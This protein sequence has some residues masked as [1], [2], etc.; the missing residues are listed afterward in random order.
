MAGETIGVEYARLN[1]FSRKIPTGLTQPINASCLCPDSSL[2]RVVGAKEKPEIQPSVQLTTLK[3][4]ALLSG[5]E[6]LYYSYPQG[7]KKPAPDL[8]TVVLDSKL[9]QLPVYNSLPEELFHASSNEVRRMIQKMIAASQKRFQQDVYSSFFENENQESQINMH[10]AITLLVQNLQHAL[11]MPDSES[12]LRIYQP[13]ER[14][15]AE[16]I[17]SIV[18][19]HILPTSLPG[20]SEKGRFN[21]DEVNTMVGTTFGRGDKVVTLAEFEE[22]S[23]VSDGERYGWIDRQRVAG[24]KE[25]ATYKDVQPVYYTG[26]QPYFYQTAIGESSSILPGDT[27]YQKGPEYFVIRKDAVDAT[28]A[29]QKVNPPKETISSMLSTPQEIADFLFGLDLPYIRGV[30]DC[31]EV[32]RRTFK[33][34]GKSVGKFSGKIMETIAKTVQAEQEITI[35]ELFSLSDGVYISN[36]YKGGTSKHISLIFVSK[37]KTEIISYQHDIEPSLYNGGRIL[38]KHIVYSKQIYR[39]TVGNKRMTVIKL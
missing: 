33:M 14:E 26:G 4:A 12:L 38:G 27:I 7:E 11:N 30:F 18:Y 2:R 17:D 19:A 10:P 21:T 37:G 16:V 8:S 36:L 5:D 35:D 24:E 9:N 3:A 34:M 20:T 13:A 25:V 23:L 1:R 31:S 6:K 32:I 28:P 22:Y 29:L 15:K 39:E